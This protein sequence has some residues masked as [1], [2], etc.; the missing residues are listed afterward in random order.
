MV[1]LTF[2]KVA[3]IGSIL[4]ILILIITLIYTH[5]LTTYTASIDNRPFETGLVGSLDTLNPALITDRKS[6]V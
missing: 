6:V 1:Y 4:G 5:N 2:R 3:L